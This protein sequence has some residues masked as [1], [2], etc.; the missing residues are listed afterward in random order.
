MRATRRTARS[1]IAKAQ[2]CKPAVALRSSIDPA[3]KLGLGA[4]TRPKEH[5]IGVP[6]RVGSDFSALQ[7]PQG[8]EPSM[9]GELVS[10]MKATLAPACSARSH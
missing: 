4:R 1:H 10:R 6:S 8:V 9:V 7:L 2:K 3:R 5:H